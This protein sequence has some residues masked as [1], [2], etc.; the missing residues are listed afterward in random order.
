MN[1][2]FP[3]L[4]KPLRVKNI[5]FKNRIEAS[6]M[7]VVPSHH[8]ISAFPD[9]GGVMFHDKSIGGA[10]ALHIVSHG[11]TSTNGY[12]SNGHD[13]FEKYQRDIMREQ[14]SVGQ[15][16]G[17]ITSLVLGINSVINDVLMGPSDL[18]GFGKKYVGLPQEEI[19]KMIDDLVSKAVQCKDFGFDELLLDIA[20]DSIVAQFMAPAYNKRTDQYGGSVENR[21]RF[22]KELITRVR[23]AL[24]DDFVIELR[25]SA[26]LHIPGSYEFEEMLQFIKSVED[27]IDIVNVISGMDEN[28][29]GN[30]NAVAMCFLPHSKN[31][32]Y[33]EAIKKNC[34]VFV[35]VGG[36]VMTPEEGEEILASGAA[37]LIMYGR[38]LI[39]DPFLP[40][41]AKCGKSDEITPCLRCNSCYHIATNHYQ[42]VCSVNP[43]YNR[44]NRVPLE[45]KPAKTSKKVAV[46]GAG[47]SGCMA[48]ATA[49]KRG[50]SVDLYEASSEVGGQL[51]LAEYGGMH[52]QD[53]KR[54][55]D[56]MKTQIEKS[57]VTFIPNTIVTP[58][59]LSE[60]DYDV[61]IVA[62]G[63]ESF[64]L[65]LSPID[66]PR[67]SNFD[68]AMKNIEKLGQN[69]VIIGGG[70]IGMEF[71][72]QLSEL[73]KNVDVIEKTDHIA[74]ASNLLYKY[75]LDHAL[76]H[77]D[78]KIHLNTIVEK[79]NNGFLTTKNKE[80]HT[81]E[82]PYDNVV[83]AI[84]MKPK[85]EEALSFM[86]TAE[87]VYYIGDCKKVAKVLEAVNDGYFIAA[88]L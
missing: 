51:K 2:F 25:L 1:K 56:Y 52:K 26:V 83:Y 42:T 12:I 55:K 11:L 20:H 79:I 33:A 53:L 28:L 58:A 37:D 10:A 29:L 23:E 45:L 13:P 68:Y 80:N 66:E 70:T 85:K 19:S 9:Y 82:I 7:G 86:E 43:R 5:V 77:T 67:V 59:S 54:Y 63:A 73:G 35:S 76:S 31:V 88:N 78:V 16:S 22:A 61:V 34:D 17:A 24:G 87:E 36:A 48:A 62:I 84:G 14:L 60:K 47:P 46:I 21:F 32:N 64:I 65:P 3:N 49:A 6:P 39:A 27:K 8:F 38:S 72:I 74:G 41:K 44:E 50:H 15:Q 40:N 18:D 30:V 75:A 69:I 81:K 57:D 4:F 71:A